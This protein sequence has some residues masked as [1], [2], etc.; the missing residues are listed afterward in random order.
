MT[1][2]ATY[3]GGI[4]FLDFI[5]EAIT[6]EHLTNEI[7]KKPDLVSVDEVVVIVD[8]YDQPSINQIN[9][10]NLF[11]E[12]YRKNVDNNTFPASSKK[13]TRHGRTRI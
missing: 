4:F 11:R 9:Q 12:H 5:G 1:V 13:S 8:T 6:L 2:P 10:Y 3:G 7:K